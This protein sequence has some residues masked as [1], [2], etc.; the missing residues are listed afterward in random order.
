M[1]VSQELRLEGIH[2]SGK[3]V[4]SVWSRHKLLT[5]LDRLLR[6]EKTMR[7]QRL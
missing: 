1:R 2:V 3:G 5:K 6:L 7:E 4:R